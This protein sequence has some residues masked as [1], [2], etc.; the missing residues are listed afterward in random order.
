MLTAG[1]EPLKLTADTTRVNFNACGLVGTGDLPNELLMHYDA[2]DSGNTKIGGG[3]LNFKIG[4]DTTKPSLRI[5]SPKNGTLVGPGEVMEIIVVGEE[6]K[7]AETWQTG[8]R[9]LTLTDSQATQTSPQTVY[10]AC[11]NNSNRE[12]LTL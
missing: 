1:G 9:R 11:D 6:S 2:F 12:S 3:Y 8:M 4:P 7:S 10:K 5:V